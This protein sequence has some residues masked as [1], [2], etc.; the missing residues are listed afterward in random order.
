MKIYVKII[1]LLLAFLCVLSFASCTASDSDDGKDGG[2]KG[3]V[4]KNGDKNEKCSHDYGKW[5][6]SE[7]ADCKGDGLRVRECSKC[8]DVE[9]E[10]IPATEHQFEKY[11][12]TKAATCTTTGVK[13]GTCTICNEKATE[14]IPKA[15]HNYGTDGK[16][17]KCSVCSEANYSV[18]TQGLLFTLQDRNDPH[19]DTY[20]VRAGTAI[21]AAE[22]TIPSTY[23]GKAVTYIEEDGFSSLVNL[24]AVNIPASV[25]QIGDYAFSYCEKLASVTY[26]SGSELETIGEASFRGCKALTIVKIPASVTLIE[27]M[28]FYQCSALSSVYFDEEENWYYKYYSNKTPIDVS[29]A[30]ENV[31]Y[32]KNNANISFIREIEEL[33]TGY[34]S[35]Y[36]TSNYQT[37]YWGW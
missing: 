36:G 23:N 35:G 37:D 32:F 1:A 8:G 17:Q 2:K 34:E 33:D 26:Q 13:T 16:A 19:P 5:T 9:E 18:G 4:S 24:T 7:A 14:T 31:A 21:R 22:I 12:V 11:T 10:T 20:M 27:E 15:E 28:A 30:R 25:K 6:I 29:D 3:E